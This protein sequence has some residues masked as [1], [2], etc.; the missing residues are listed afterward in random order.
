MRSDESFSI[1]NN[2]IMTCPKK[3]KNKL[4]TDN[5][6]KSLL[7]LQKDTSFLN[8]KNSNSKCNALA[9]IVIDNNVMFVSAISLRRS[10]TVV[11]R[12][13]F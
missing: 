2:K 11:V 9:N 7:F 8:V 6:V 1:K 3:S 12:Q 13:T 4:R 10:S 5:P